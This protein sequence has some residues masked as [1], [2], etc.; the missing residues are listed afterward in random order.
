[1]KKKDRGTNR[2]KLIYCLVGGM[3]LIMAASVFYMRYKLSSISKETEQITKKYEKHYAMIT[4]DTEK[5][6][7]DSVYRAASQEG[8]ER[9]I[10][11][12]RFGSNLNY[13]YSKSELMQ[14]AIDA[15]VDGIILEGDESPELT[16][17]INLAQESDIPVVTVKN[18]CS[19]SERISFVGISSYNLGKTYGNKLLSL[20]TE[21]TNKVYVL[22][23]AD[24]AD[25]SQDIVVS[26]IRD[27]ID[28][29]SQKE[30]DYVIEGVA[31]DSQDAFG[32]EEAIR[33]IFLDDKNLPD[34][35]ICLNSVFTK[36]A[37]QAAVDY[38]KVGQVNILGYYDSDD[39]LE[40]VSKN[41]LQ[42]TISIDTES[43]GRMSVQALQEYQKTGYVSTYMAV[44]SRMIGQYYALSMLEERKQEVENEK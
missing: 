18:D 42:S 37:F 31:I 7:W 39:I 40:A 44:D 25:L 34:V 6:F 14:I 15:A 21:E 30:I 43:M 41:I 36:C 12:E 3:V 28:T 38:N 35:M 16:S 33:D 20:L 19:A 5:E 32:S 11:V 4:D 17:M 10:F 8:E 9:Q 23:D 1:M 29:V 26:G 24:I 2:I 13:K 22:M 27:A